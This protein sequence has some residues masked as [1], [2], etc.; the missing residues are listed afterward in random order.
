[1]CETK[2]T[3]TVAISYLAMLD[4]S[5]C[6][7][8]LRE[9]ADQVVRVVGGT[10]QRHSAGERNFCKNCRQLMKL[11]NARNQRNVMDIPNLV[12]LEVQYIVLFFLPLP[13]LFNIAQL[14]SEF[15]VLATFCVSV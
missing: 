3:S 15:N 7:V 2:L 14:K 5:F 1:M 9:V 10:S 4:F 11:L 12:F 13:V 8:P 6:R